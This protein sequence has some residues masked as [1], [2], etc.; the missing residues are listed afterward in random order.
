MA[1][2]TI[3]LLSSREIEKMRQAGRLAAELLDYLEPMVKPG[4][5]TLDLNDEAERWTKLMVQK[6]L[7]LAITAFLGQSVLV[8]MRLSV[9]VS[10]TLNKY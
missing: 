1:T 5:S 10:L 8:L 2:E 3:V 7:L 6:A 4:V 9:T